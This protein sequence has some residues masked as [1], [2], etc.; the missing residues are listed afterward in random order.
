MPYEATRTICRIVGHRPERL[1]DITEED[2]RAEGII[3]GG[4]L[5]CGEHEPCGCPNPRPDARDAFIHLWKSIHG[6]GSWEK[7]QWLW[8]ITLERVR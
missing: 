1:Q 4:C 8:A 2:A 3:D 7:N 6:E 5:N